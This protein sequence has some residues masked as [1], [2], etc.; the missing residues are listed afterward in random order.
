MA[1]HSSQR[2]DLTGLVEAFD[3]APVGF[4]EVAVPLVESGHA[5]LVQQLLAEAGG[6]EL[7][8]V[9]RTHEATVILGESQRFKLA[10]ERRGDPLHR[11][12]EQ[13]Q[14]HEALHLEADV[15]I[16]RDPQAVERPESWVVPGRDTR[17]RT[18]T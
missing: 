7:V 4:D 14:E 11:M 13:V 5:H 6:L 17:W 15:G 10:F 3:V 12:A 2:W 9:Q 18:R 8:G 16:D 1:T